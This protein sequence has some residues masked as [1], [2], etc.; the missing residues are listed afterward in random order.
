VWSVAE[1]SAK[2]IW[3]ERFGADDLLSAL[4]RNSAA[5]TAETSNRSNSR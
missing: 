2:A 5:K 1:Q 4:A 3:I